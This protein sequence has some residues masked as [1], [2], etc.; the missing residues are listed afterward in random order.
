MIVLYENLRHLF[1]I[2]LEIN[3]IS[4]PSMINCIGDEM[5]K[6]VEPIVINDIHSDI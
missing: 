2:D 4:C 6:R 5:S 1:Q 3:Y